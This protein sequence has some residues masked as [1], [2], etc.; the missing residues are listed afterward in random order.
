MDVVGAV[1]AKDV[2]VL[3]QSTGAKPGRRPWQRVLVIVHPAIGDG[4]VALD[5]GEIIEPVWRESDAAHGLDLAAGYHRRK[6]KAGLLKR[7][8][9][10]PL[11]AGEV[12]ALA[13]V[14]PGV[15]LEAC[16][17]RI[18]VVAAQYIERVVKGGG[19]RIVVGHQQIRPDLPDIAIGRVYLYRRKKP[20][21]A[22]RLFEA[23]PHYVNSVIHKG[24][25]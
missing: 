15:G 12:A 8:N 21:L 7:G 9:F 22:V 19:G 3:A 1:S 16:F 24:S 17:G 4:V 13:E 2:D 11:A 5:Q 23:A 25:N 18:R 6:S 14:E 10:L 20:E